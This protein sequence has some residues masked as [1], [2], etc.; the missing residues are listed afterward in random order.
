M[1]Q[2]SAS[3]SFSDAFDGDADDAVDAS[4]SHQEIT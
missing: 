3:T 2:Q 4:A 1:T